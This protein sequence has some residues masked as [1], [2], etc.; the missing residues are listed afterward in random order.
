MNVEAVVKWPN[1]VARAPVLTGR[2]SNGAPD[3][4]PAK[5]GNQYGTRSLDSL[6]SRIGRIRKIERRVPAYLVNLT[7]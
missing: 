5:A 7:A 1:P 3:V 4:V 2:K 6:A